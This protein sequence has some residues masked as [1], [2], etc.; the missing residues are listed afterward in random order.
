[1][2]KSE[3]YVTQTEL[4]D[5]QG[6][7]YATEN[8]VNKL[9]DEIDSFRKTMTWYTIILFIVSMIAIGGLFL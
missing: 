6:E 5:V 9:K 2:D 7:F 8:E 1:M 4:L 3:T